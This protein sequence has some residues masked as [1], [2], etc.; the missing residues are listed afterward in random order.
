MHESWLYNPTTSA[1]LSIFFLIILPLIPN[2]FHLFPVLIFRSLY[3]NLRYGY[4]REVVAS[5]E[6]SYDMI[7]SAISMK[8]G[9]LWIDPDRVIFQKSAVGILNYRSSLLCSGLSG[10]SLSSVFWLILGATLSMQ[11]SENS[12][13]RRCYQVSIIRHR[14]KIYTARS[15]EDVY[16]MA[17]VQS[18][19]DPYL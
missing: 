6:W 4:T 1:E 13:A 9:I 5:S 11:Y 8:L 2:P 7:S 16:I 3:T 18:T 10:F 19:W 12:I 15:A 17:I 14:S